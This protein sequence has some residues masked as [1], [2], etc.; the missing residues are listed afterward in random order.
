MNMME[1]CFDYSVYAKIRAMSSGGYSGIGEIAICPDDFSIGSLIPFTPQTR[2]DELIA[3][4]VELPDDFVES[5]KNFYEALKEAEK[6]RVWISDSPYELLGLY[7]ISNYVY[8]K[9]QE[10]YVC[11]MAYLPNEYPEN[12]LSCLPG[13]EWEK[14]IKYSKIVATKEFSKLWGSLLNENSKLRITLNNQIVSVNVDYFDSDILAV[15]AKL[16]TDDIYIIADTALQNYTKNENVI[17]SIYFFLYRTE[18]LLSTN[19]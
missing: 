18:K 13:E 2:H 12:C 6:V 4:G 14:L 16:K 1:I 19:K 8:P 15:A 10:I 17:F 7:F 3:N 9:I 11:S 5:Y